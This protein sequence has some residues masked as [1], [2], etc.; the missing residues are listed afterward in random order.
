VGAAALVRGVGDV[1]HAGGSALSWFSPIAWAQQTRPFVDLRWTPLLLSVLLIGVLVAA[2]YR[3]NRSRDVGAGLLAARRGPAA[4][5]PLLTG[6]LP[7]LARLQRGT[8][9]GWA[10]A[11]VLLGA[12]FGSLTD[13]VLSMVSKNPTLAR[14]F[15][16]SGASI[17]DSFTA[18][19]TLEFGLCAG[20]FAVASVLRLRSEETAG[21]AE[22]LLAT[23]LDRR[24]LLGSGL[25]VTALGA[26]LLLA[27]AGLGNGL[28]SAAVSGDAGLVGRDLGAALVHLPAVLVLAGGTALLVGLVPRRAGLAWLVVVW[29]VLAGV[30]GT[31]L[32]VP[33]WAL[34]L[35]PFGWTPKVP[36]EGVDVASLG[37]LIVVAALLLV[38]ALATFRRR[39]VP[40]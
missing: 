10:V 9:I 6:P 30:F 28:T 31:L 14:I 35:S 32:N 15:A 5:S 11:L 40:S 29:A 7:L 4:A 2:A 16:A 26:S 27:A 13:S 36:A 24:R 17:P 19:T 3:L 20:A 39:D 18:A 38:A 12:T 25:T 34:K 33:S 1:V 22:L 23:P 8:I 37:G 21:R